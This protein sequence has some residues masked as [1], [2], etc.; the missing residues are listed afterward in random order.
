MSQPT[1]RKGDVNS[2]EPAGSHDLTKADPCTRFESLDAPG[3]TVGMAQMI[4]RPGLSACSA[5]PPSETS[6]VPPVSRMPIE[7]LAEVFVHLHALIWLPN[8]IGPHVSHDIEETVARVCTTWRVVARG[9]P[10]LWSAIGI[11]SLYRHANKYL[12][13][14]LQLSGD[15][16]LSIMC[17]PKFLSPTI[18]AILLPH[19]RRYEHLWIEHGSSAAEGWIY[20]LLNEQRDF[21]RLTTVGIGAD[22]W[23][24]STPG[25]FDFL[26][27]A[28]QL[29]KLTVF[30]FRDCE[31]DAILSIPP[32]SSLTELDLTY[33]HADL[34]ALLTTLSPSGPVLQEIYVD[35]SREQTF[36]DTQP[37][38]MSALHTLT[39]YDT[40]H[41]FMRYIT[42][43]NIRAILL[44]AIDEHASPCLS[45]LTFASST[46]S[47]Q[48][49][50]SIEIRDGIYNFD[51]E[52]SRMLLRSFERMD[53]LRNLDLG[54]EIFSM[55]IKSSISKELYVGL[56]IR[57]DA[58]VALLPALESLVLP[59][60]P[61]QTAE[62][63]ALVRSRAV[64]RVV[65]GQT[66]VA[67]DASEHRE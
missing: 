37:I 51:E 66:V 4:S 63:N 14:C 40:G 21:A 16:S 50:Q 15:H 55:S 1:G 29:K 52:A 20:A 30:F 6:L 34:A 67:L 42:A 49:L 44:C 58:A 65:G 22:V 47:L 36:P 18:L 62:W 43:P 10:K 13:T 56:T 2:D 31:S 24:T 61:D 3:E 5:N 48:H 12:S 38:I 19:S 11:V 33:K 60:W 54:S 59:Y 46:A 39:C 35:F 28:P 23:T 27:Y 53:A 8:G 9:T 7:L 26:A 45:L 57:D 17:L 41:I 32:L 25:I 64:S